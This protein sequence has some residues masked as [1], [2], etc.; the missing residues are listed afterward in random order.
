VDNWP[1]KIRPRE[2][3]GREKGERTRLDLCDSMLR[4][5]FALEHGGE[6]VAG[7]GVEAIRSCLNDELASISR[8]RRVRRSIAMESALV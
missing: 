6:D 3:E 2:G 7:F 8:G 4:A 5:G 1:E